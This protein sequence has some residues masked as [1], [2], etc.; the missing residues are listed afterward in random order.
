MVILPHLKC[1]N[2]HINDILQESHE[3][4]PPQTPEYLDHI[5][6]PL[7]SKLYGLTDAKRS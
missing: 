2:K 7:A 4:L 1:N 3:Q 6:S 5:T